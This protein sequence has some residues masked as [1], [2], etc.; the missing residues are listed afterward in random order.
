VAHLKGE[1]LAAPAIT[2]KVVVV[3]T[4]DGKLRGVD[5]SDGHDLWTA[6][7]SMPSCR[8]GVRLRR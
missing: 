8:Y 5:T 1:I 6:E 2:E 7:Q 3:R 4:V